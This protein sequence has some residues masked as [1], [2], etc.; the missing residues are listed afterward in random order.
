MQRKIPLPGSISRELARCDGFVL[1]RPLAA[2]DEDEFDD[3]FLGNMT[4]QELHDKQVSLVR[5]SCACPGLIPRHNIRPVQ[6]SAV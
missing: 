4:Q 5:E 1:P 3:D 2:D 6:P